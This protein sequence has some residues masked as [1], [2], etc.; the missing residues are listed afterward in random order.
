MWKDCGKCGEG[1]GFT[2]GGEREGDGLEEEV[3]WG[4]R[5]G[6]WGWDRHEIMSV[7]VEVREWGFF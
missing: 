1:D 6:G 5:E 3:G 2:E 7:D 4:E